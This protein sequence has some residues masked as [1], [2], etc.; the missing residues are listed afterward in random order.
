MELR[1]RILQIYLHDIIRPEQLWKQ[2]DLKRKEDVIRSIAA[3]GAYL[4]SN[5]MR[6]ALE[7]WLREEIRLI[8]VEQGST[9]LQEQQTKW[10]TAFADEVIACMEKMSA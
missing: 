7:R 1:Q 4:R 3:F 8:E 6:E 10:R 9:W 5:E 2:Q